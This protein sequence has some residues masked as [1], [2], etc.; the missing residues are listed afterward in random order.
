MKDFFVSQASNVTALLQDMTASGGS[1]IDLLFPIVYDELRRL[2]ERHLKNERRNHTLQPTALAHEAYLKLVH[3]RTI[4]W[5]D[6]LHFF[7]AAGQAIR[8]ILVD[9]ARGLNRKKR[10]RQRVFLILDSLAQA[11]TDDFAHIEALD[12]ALLKLHAESPRK[13]RVVE[14]RFFSGFSSDEAATLL[15]V[16]TRTVE[17][18]W[19]YARAWLFRELNSSAVQ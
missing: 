14:L 8:R 17:R 19:R 9:H 5:Q 15:G 13:A 3:Q 4:P 7:G 11:E 10:A 16:T 12:G 1:E 6:R 18:D 2:A